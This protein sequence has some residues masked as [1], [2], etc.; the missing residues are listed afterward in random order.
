M[1]NKFVTDGHAADGEPGK[2]LVVGGDTAV[3]W[4]LCPADGLDN[5]AENWQRYDA[6]RSKPRPG[7]ACL[8]A[9]MLRA[10]LARKGIAASVDAPELAG[11]IGRIPPP[12]THPCQRGARSR[13]SQEG[14][15]EAHVPAR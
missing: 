5:A 8:V 4:F 2:V 12:G 7:G 3:D 15:Q 6:L 10:A 11:N 1:S 13:H 14:R 9:E